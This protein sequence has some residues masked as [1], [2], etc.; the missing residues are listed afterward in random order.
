MTTNDIKQ[1]SSK[2]KEI[3]SEYSRF[4]KPG[5]F[6][7]YVTCTIS[8]EENEDIVYGFLNENDDF[9]KVPAVSINSDLFG[10]LMDEECF[11]KSMPHKHNTDGFFGAV[12]RR[13]QV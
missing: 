2:Q 3:I 10:K 13:I 7:V 6:L 4:V 11:F 8:R 12:M 9:Q 5:G 1:L